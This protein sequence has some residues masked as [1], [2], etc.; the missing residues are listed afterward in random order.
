[1]APYASDSYTKQL[2]GKGELIVDFLLGF[3]LGPIGLFLAGFI[4]HRRGTIEYTMEGCG[5][6]FVGWGLWIV[7]EFILVN[8]GV[9]IAFWSSFNM[10]HHGWH[11]FILVIAILHVILWSMWVY[12]MKWKQTPEEKAY[13]LHGDD[14]IKPGERHVRYDSGITL[15]CT[16]DVVWQHVRQCGQSKAGWYSFDWLERFFTFDIHN[17]Y[18]I[19]PEWQSM[20]PGDFQWFH[21]AP[22]TIGEW[23]TEVS[24]DGPWYFASHSDTRTDKE[25]PNQERAF[26]V[27]GLKY[28]CWTWNWEA[29]A[30]S[31]T[32]C[33]LIW[34]CDC[35][36]KPYARPIKWLIV[37]TL[38]TASIVMGRN[39]LDVMEKVV[40]GTMKIE[41]KNI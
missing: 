29:Y 10:A 21:Q 33:R 24:N 23:I 19:H 4:A 9:D 38:G 13:V 22:L 16:P 34:R 27:P 37:F 25:G 36:F 40:T 3:L 41:P 32:Q 35:T 15:D 18:T 17:H 14:W 28:F 11:V 5:E 8:C 26:A 20:E 7:I 30:I 6:A 39:F 31:P 12:G 1:M 2:T